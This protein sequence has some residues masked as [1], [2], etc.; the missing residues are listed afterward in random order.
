[1]CSCIFLWEGK[2]PICFY[3]LGTREFS[4]TVALRGWR[5]DHS[6]TDVFPAVAEAGNPR[7]MT[8]SW[9][10]A[11]L[12]ANW[13]KL[14]DLPADLLSGGCCPAG[15]RPLLKQCMCVCTCV[16]SHL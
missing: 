8:K 9:L 6:L 3:S 1:M 13:E 15:S 14:E 16:Y 5:G 4:P 7:E 2:S 11:R 10:P 12:G